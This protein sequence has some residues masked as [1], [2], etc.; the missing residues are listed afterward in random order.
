M[1]C[2]V[3]A[4]LLFSGSVDNRQLVLDSAWLGT[5][6]PFM[7][8]WLWPSCGISVVV[9]CFRFGDY[10]V[11]GTRF[12]MVVCLVAMSVCCHFLSVCGWLGM[13]YLMFSPSD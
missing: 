9:G 8:A 5:Q 2:S 3:L 12:N 4:G 11:G 13:C 7:L 10:F 1:T 6:L